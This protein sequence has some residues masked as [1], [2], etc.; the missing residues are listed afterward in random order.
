VKSVSRL[1]E[2]L[3][4]LFKQDVTL[5]IIGTHYPEHWNDMELDEIAWMVQNYVN[6]NDDVIEGDPLKD[7]LE[8]YK[9]FRADQGSG[10]RTA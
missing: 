2:K 8:E 7:W 6:R 3:Q 10:N 4:R 5:S 9:F 1:Q